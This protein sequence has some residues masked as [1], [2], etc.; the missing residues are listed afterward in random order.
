MIDNGDFS[1][2]EEDFGVGRFVW[3]T[4]KENGINKDV[5]CGIG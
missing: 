2:P 5:L 1:I 3:G 4:I